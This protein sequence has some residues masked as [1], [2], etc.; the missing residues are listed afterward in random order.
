M[1]REC[2]ASLLLGSDGGHH[3]LSALC[4]HM[5]PW[6]KCE[7][8]KVRCV[9]GIVAIPFPNPPPVFLVWAELAM[10][11]FVSSQRIRAG[12]TSEASLLETRAY[13]K[14]VTNPE[15]HSKIRCP[16]VGL[17]VNVTL[18]HLLGISSMLLL[19]LFF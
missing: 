17:L 3:P 4:P 15:S 14:K 10:V 11:G 2:G 5:S 6:R 19:S 7:N 13:D 8:R 16:V 9:L 1:T 18:A 12:R